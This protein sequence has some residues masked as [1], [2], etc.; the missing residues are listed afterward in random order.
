MISSKGV[1]LF[2]GIFKG[3]RL[4]AN[5]LLYSHCP[6]CSMDMTSHK[7]WHATLE[8]QEPVNKK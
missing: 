3:S 7:V 5:G 4:A 6:F 2:K 8:T 1:G